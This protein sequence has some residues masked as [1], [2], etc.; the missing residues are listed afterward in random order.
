MNYEQ[1]LERLL[2]ISSE[3]SL[4]PDEFIPWD[5]PL[6][7]DYAYLP[8]H[9]ISLYN[10]PIY[11]TLTKSQKL[12][13]GK[14]EVCQVLYS[15]LHIENVLCVFLNRYLLKIDPT[16]LESR[17]IIKELIE[18]YRHQEFFAKALRLIDRKP[19]YPNRL[20]R[21]I[22]MF[23]V[24]Y[25]S[26]NVTFLSCLA[27]EMIADR[28]GNELTICEDVHPILRKITQLHSIEESRHIL[29]AKSLLEKR[30]IKDKNVFI[31]TYYGIV[32]MSSIWYMRSLYVNLPFYKAIGI[33]D[34]KKHYRLAKKAYRFR[35]GQLCNKDIV[36]FLKQINADTLFT[37][38]CWKSILKVKL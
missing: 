8:P 2:R 1:K 25:T 34:S 36:P 11:N 16:S 37:K 29:F 27:V 6:G 24:K 32:L 19:I 12:E 9:L 3:K 26:L 10:Q 22:G 15:Y 30:G 20:Q 7:D 17:Y 4:D 23:T 38:W 14:L 31:R 5:L 21:F 35:F 33:T 18:E 28:Y 13:L